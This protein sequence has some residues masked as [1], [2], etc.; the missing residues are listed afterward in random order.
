[1]GQGE[2]AVF[3]PDL[4]VRRIIVK[5]SVCPGAYIKSWEVEN[6]PLVGKDPRCFDH[7]GAPDGEAS[8]S[9]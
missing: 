9:A 4:C 1:M 2:K 3:Q 8:L 5:V 6:Q 7:K